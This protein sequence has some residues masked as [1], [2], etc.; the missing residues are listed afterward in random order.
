MAFCGFL[1]GLRFLYPFIWHCKR[2]VGFPSRASRGSRQSA[3]VK[4][5]ATCPKVV[6]QDSA[7]S[8]GDRL[9]HRAAVKALSSW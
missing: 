8:G 9:S 3:D 7:L 4:A 5:C 6:A 2:S 1:D